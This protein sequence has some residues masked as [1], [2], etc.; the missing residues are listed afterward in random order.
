M[1]VY[2]VADLA[3]GDTLD[4]YM[5]TAA[6]NLDP[7]VALLEGSADLQALQ[8]QYQADLQQLLA[9]GGDIAP[10]LEALRKRYFLAWDD[11]GGHGYAAALSYPVTAGGDYLLLAG[12]SLSALGRAT[13]GAYTLTV[14]INAP[15]VLTGEGKP[16]SA[17]SHATHRRAR[18]AAPRPGAARCRRSRGP[19]R[20][21]SHW[22]CSSWPTLIPATCWRSS[23]PRPAV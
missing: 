14:G 1:Q 18:P 6:G 5:Q 10:G 23:S 12:G 9:E 20:R 19:S 16:A 4:V 8:T 11:D 22:L 17:L 15:Q 3:P 2:R 13:S 7:F 21:S